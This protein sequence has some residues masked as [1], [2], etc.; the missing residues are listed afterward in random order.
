[1]KKIDIVSQDKDGIYI[2]N[3]NDISY[4]NSAGDAVN[5]VNETHES[6]PL[7]V[8]EVYNRFSQRR[9]HNPIK[10]IIDD[11]GNLVLLKD[12]IQEPFEL[13]RMDSKRKGAYKYGVGDSARLV[14]LMGRDMNS[15]DINSIIDMVNEIS[16]VNLYSSQKM[17]VNLE[18]GSIT[19]D[20]VNA[21]DYT[22]TISLIG[23]EKKFAKY[24]LS[25]KIDLT[26]QYS[27][28]GD[29]YVQD[30]SFQGF[31]YSGD[32]LNPT[33]EQ[34]NFVSPMTDVLVEYIDGIIRI[35]PESERVDECIISNCVI[36]YGRI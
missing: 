6:H 14:S 5:I 36:T 11:S 28:N 34:L 17:E 4:K 10:K 18:T 12:D 27:V 7:C 15:E 1:M 3:R 31:K 29:V 19:L 9:W 23:V 8:A 22:N 2:D 32:E 33:L 30:L 35:I 26:V 21:K 16:S 13:D 20:L 24:K 25:G